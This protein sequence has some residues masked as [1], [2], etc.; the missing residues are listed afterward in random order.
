MLVS[1]VAPMHNEAPSLEAFYR[2]LTQCL[3]DEQKTRG[4]Y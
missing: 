1:V 2:R 4:R 3:A